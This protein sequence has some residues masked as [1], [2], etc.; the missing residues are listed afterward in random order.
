[1]ETGHWKSEI[2]P[3]YSNISHPLYHPPFTLP[4]PSV[5]PEWHSRGGA[6][7]HSNDDCVPMF[8]SAGFSVGSSEPCCAS[9]C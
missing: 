3:V 7:L 2:K 1:L 6:L 5:I 8:L 4:V 9:E